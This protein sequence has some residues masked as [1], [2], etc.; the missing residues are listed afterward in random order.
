MYG[1][2]QDGMC[3]LPP[4]FFFARLTVNILGRDISERIFLHLLILDAMP[5]GY[6]VDSDRGIQA[7]DSRHSAV[8]LSL[9]HSL[10]RMHTC[11]LSLPHIDTYITCRPWR[12]KRFQDAC[13]YRYRV[14]AH[15]CTKLEARIH[16][17]LHFYVTICAWV[18]LQAFLMNTGIKQT[19]PACIC[20]N[21]QTHTQSLS[22]SHMHIRTRTY[23]HTHTHT[24]T[25]AYARRH[26]NR[27]RHRLSRRLSSRHR[28]EHRHKHKHRYRQRYWQRQRH[29]RTLWRGSDWE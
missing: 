1:R 22:P 23:E 10:A 3:N 8:L 5:Q 14:A 16:I 4:I 11:L 18:F 6:P 26:K 17:S 27:L 15:T 21:T 20:S 25:Q 19:F 24:H 28:H 12:R 2:K 29:R 13:D 9:A 7:H